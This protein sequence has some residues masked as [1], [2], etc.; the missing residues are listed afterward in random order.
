MTPCCLNTFVLPA[1]LLPVAIFPNGCSLALPVV[2]PSQLLSLDALKLA[3]VHLKKCITMFS[4]KKLQ[5]CTCHFLMFPIL[6]FRNLSSLVIN[7]RP[8]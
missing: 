2:G 7:G 1:F 6:V 5:V 4:L 3:F 8:S